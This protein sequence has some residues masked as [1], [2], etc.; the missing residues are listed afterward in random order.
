MKIN[1]KLR[2]KSKTFWVGILS[3]TVN[4]V[5]Q[6]LSQLGVETVITQGMAAELISLALTVLGALGIIVDPTTKG[7]CDSERVI[8]Y[9]EPN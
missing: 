1:W 9:R 6:L 5:F 3:I 4:F 8:N 7:V 2:F